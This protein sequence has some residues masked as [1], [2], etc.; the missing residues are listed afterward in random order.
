MCIYVAYKCI[1]GH[2]FIVQVIYNFSISQF[3]KLK[4]HDYDDDDD[5]YDDYDNDDN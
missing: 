2:A 3:F 4:D 5:D 1:V